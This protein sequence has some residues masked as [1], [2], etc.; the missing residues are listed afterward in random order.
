[1]KILKVKK[2]KLGFTLVEMVVTLLI[3]VTLALL[4]FP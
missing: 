2:K 3:I 1:M 4:S